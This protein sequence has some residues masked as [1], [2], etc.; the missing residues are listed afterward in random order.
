MNKMNPSK[1]RS[2]NVI[3]VML[4]VL[5]LL[6]VLGVAAR[7]LLDRRYSDKTEERT[8]SFTMILPANE[9]QTL[10][11]G[12]VVRLSS[13]Q[14]LGSIETIVRA[15]SIH[16]MTGADLVK[17]TAV[18]GQLTVL[19]YVDKTGVFCSMDGIKLRINDCLTLENGA[20]YRFY[21][22]NIVENGQ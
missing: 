15:V 22:D 13:G 4:M 6:L 12:S 9:A 17:R 20:D 21:I 5:A 2:L 7:V 8:I 19:G 10:M 11:Q 3:D 18:T 16:E 14:K 1:K